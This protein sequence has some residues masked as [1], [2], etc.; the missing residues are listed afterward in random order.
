MNK[1]TK[2]YRTRLAADTVRYRS[3]VRKLPRKQKNVNVIKEVIFRSPETEAALEGLFVGGMLWIAGIGLL[4]AT[5]KVPMW[6]L[7]PKFF[8]SVIL[9]YGNARKSIEHTIS[10][11]DLIELGLKKMGE[12]YIQN[13]PF[14]VLKHMQKRGKKVEHRVMIVSPWGQGA[15]TDK[16]LW[17]L[18]QLMPDIA[19]AV[20]PFTGG[21]VIVPPI[22]PLE[23]IKDVKEILGYTPEISQQTWTKVKALIEQGDMDLGTIKV[24][25]NVEE[26]E[27][28]DYFDRDWKGYIAR[29]LGILF[30]LLF[31]LND[32]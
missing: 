11:G 4:M 27:I 1:T 26:Y 15:N 24:P 16:V 10:P 8:T 7:G 25:P 32:L 3:R 28:E 13:A 31:P 29:M 12:F 19:V 23:E 17:Y 2:R 6:T 9:S 22:R 18:Q 5:E 30:L 20:L 21:K 14:V